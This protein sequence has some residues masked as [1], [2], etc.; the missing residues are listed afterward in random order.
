M[1]K[2]PLSFLLNGALLWLAVSAAIAGMFYAIDPMRLF[3]WHEDSTPGGFCA[4]RGV[5]TVAEFD[6][7]NPERHYD[8]FIIGSSLAMYFES[9]YWQRYLPEGSVACHLDAWSLDTRELLQTVN[10]LAERA[11]IRNALIVWEL[12]AF[13]WHLVDKMTLRTAPRIEDR[14]PSLFKTYWTFFGH[15]YSRDF[16]YGWIDA[17]LLDAEL[18]GGAKAQ[19]VDYEIDHERDGIIYDD[20]GRQEMADSFG[21]SHPRLTDP[22]MRSMM[23]YFG[24]NKIDEY[25]EGLLRQTAA[26]LDELGTDYY[27]VM[28]PKKSR[29]I[30]SVR[31]DS[32]LRDIFGDRYVFTQAALSYLTRNPY[33]YRKDGYHMLPIGTRQ[34]MDYVY[35]RRKNPEKEY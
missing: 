14:L 1:S 3:R 31:D 12:D 24:Q 7:F 23:K 15:W 34:V 25:L 35:R 6:H 17:A 32:L 21:I 18:K 20:G 4:N 19:V 13:D 8:S 26:R 11:P 33:N 27:F 2:T 10:Y 30:P 9:D 28:M 22:A 5:L 16:L 29:E